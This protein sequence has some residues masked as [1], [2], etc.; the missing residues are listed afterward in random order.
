VYSYFSI[1]VTLVDSVRKRGNLSLMF[2]HLGLLRKYAVMKVWAPRLATYW[3]LSAANL[4]SMPAVP[5][6]SKSYLI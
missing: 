4:K 2:L 1:P 6:D 3:I 5:R